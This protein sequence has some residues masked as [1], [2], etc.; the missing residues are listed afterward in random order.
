MKYPPQVT[1][2]PDRHFLRMLGCERTRRWI[3]SENEKRRYINHH[4]PDIRMEVSWGISEFTNM[5]EAGLPFNSGFFYRGKWSYVG[6]YPTMEEAMVQV[7]SAVINV[8]RG[9]IEQQRKTI[10]VL[11]T[12]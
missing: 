9:Q 12:L 8:I 2:Y 7:Q 4:L 5:G 3:G 1:V 11:L 10:D 6:H